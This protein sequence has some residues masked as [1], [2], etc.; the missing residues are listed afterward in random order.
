MPD[1]LQVKDINPDYVV[2][3]R[4]RVFTRICTAREMA[5]E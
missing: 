4:G 2:L 1:D 5:K 3:Q